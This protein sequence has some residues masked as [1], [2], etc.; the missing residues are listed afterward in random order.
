MAQTPT[1][2]FNPL[3]GQRMIFRKTGKETK[4]SLLEIES[5]NPPSVDK[6]PVHI[7][8]LQESSAEVLSGKLHF[9]V[10]GKT[11]AVGPGEKIVIP[12]GAP[13]SFWN[14]GPEEAHSIQ[15]FSPALTIETFF[16]TYFALARDGK[17]NKKGTANPFL[18]ARVLLYHQNDIRL[19]KP[20]WA[21]QK[22]AYSAISPIGSLLGY[23]NKYE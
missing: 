1:A 21:V 14:E 23:K 8:P 9:N 3:S 19:T 11:F 16:R 20:P 13:H 2:I 7:H 4:G 18:M 22:L 12:P 15:H 10:N 6:E 5:F 17:I